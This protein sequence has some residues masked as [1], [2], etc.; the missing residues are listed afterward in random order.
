MICSDKHEKE[1]VI[2]VFFK[3]LNH[4]IHI[5][6]VI[7]LCSQLTHLLV[8]LL[9]LCLQ[10]FYTCAALGP[11][12]RKAWVDFQPQESRSRHKQHIWREFVDAYPTWMVHLP[13]NRE[14]EP[15]QRAV[16][17]QWNQGQCPLRLP[18]ITTVS[19]QRGILP[20]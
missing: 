6:I 11:V 20:G 12:L 1:K 16:Y 18:G 14:A 5:W 7:I 8:V 13:G 15:C 9:S 4:G 17:W 3:I 10:I 2:P 19:S